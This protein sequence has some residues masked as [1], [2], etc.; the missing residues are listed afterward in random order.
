M[1]ENDDNPPALM[2]ENCGTPAPKPAAAEAFDVADAARGNSSGAE[3]REGAVPPYARDKGNGIAVLSGCFLLALLIIVGS[4]F[5]FFYFTYS[6]AKAPVEKMGTALA[7][8]AAETWQASKDFINRAPESAYK[9]RYEFVSASEENK[10]VVAEITED[11]SESFE[12]SKWKL[13]NGDVSL[14][15]RASF[16]YFIPLS[17][18]KYEVRPSRKSGRYDFKFFFEDIALDTPVKRDVLK[19]NISQSRFSADVNAALDNYIIK[20]F[21]KEL[22]AR[23]EDLRNMELARNLAAKRMERYVREAFFPL[24]GV[25]EN[26]IGELEMV[27]STKEMEAG[28]VNADVRK[29]SAP[30]MDKRL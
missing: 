10:Y 8:A 22:E 28:A 4:V 18:F 16:Q 17:G 6:V 23:G 20:D 24:V 11:I 2:P 26:E 5:A 25:A 15:V 27:F 13:L 7:S 30:G 9:V 14:K 3:C 12:S 19:I 21:P 1:P 29:E